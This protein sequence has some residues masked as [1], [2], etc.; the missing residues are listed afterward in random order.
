RGTR[1]RWRR[2]TLDAPRRARLDALRRARPSRATGPAP[3]WA[4]LLC[5][6]DR[7]THSP[8]ASPAGNGPA[9]AGGY[10]PAPGRGAA[11][12]WPPRPGALKRIEL[13]H[14][15]TPSVTRCGRAE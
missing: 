13:D 8:G 1:G 6:A 5:D 10:P 12:R 14:V 11:M 3:V 2:A 4:R 15:L 9:E 7:P